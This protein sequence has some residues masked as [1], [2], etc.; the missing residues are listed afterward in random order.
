MLETFCRDL[1]I[2]RIELD[3]VGDL[4]DKVV[5]RTDLGFS[6]KCGYPALHPLG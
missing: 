6:L 1:A 4:R 3:S 2:R 5:L